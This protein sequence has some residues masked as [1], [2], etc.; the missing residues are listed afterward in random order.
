[1]KFIFQ[2]DKGLSKARNLGFG[3]ARG[4]IIAY[5]DDDAIPCEAWITE[6]TAPFLTD[7]S[8]KFLACGGRVIADYRK[9]IRPSWMT[10]D[11]EHYLSC[12]DWGDSARPLRTGEWI[13]G[14]NS[15]NI[16]YCIGSQ[17]NYEFIEQ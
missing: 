17:R 6:I 5:L 4:E 10:A 7:K 15:R 2:D 16:Q 12:I 11:L 14:A 13:V 1:V 8:E 9:S 3:A